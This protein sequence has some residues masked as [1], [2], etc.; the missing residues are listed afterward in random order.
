VYTQTIALLSYEIKLSAANNLASEILLPLRSYL[1]CIISP[2]AT[3]SLIR[4]KEHKMTQ[5]Q[6]NK[7]I[8]N[9]VTESILVIIIILKGGKSF[10]FLIN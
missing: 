4:Y 6:T 10:A 9:H 2:Y 5:T 8:P 1:F 3:R 7:R